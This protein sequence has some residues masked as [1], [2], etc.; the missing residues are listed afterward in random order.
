MYKFRKDVGFCYSASFLYRL[1]LPIEKRF[2]RIKN[3]FLVCIIILFGF[4]VVCVWDIFTLRMFV[5]VNFID[6]F[7]AFFAE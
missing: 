5:D 4:Y 2:F 1:I 3:L 6:N 7:S